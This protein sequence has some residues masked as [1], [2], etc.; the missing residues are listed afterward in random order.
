VIDPVDLPVDQVE[1]DPDGGDQTVHDD[2][3]IA[4]VEIRP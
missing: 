2:L 1:G 3:W 4:A